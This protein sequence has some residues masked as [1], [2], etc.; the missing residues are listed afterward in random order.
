VEGAVPIFGLGKK[1][2]A[3][4][5]DGRP[6]RVLAGGDR[7]A[8]GLI[9]AAQAQDWSKIHGTLTRLQGR[10]LSAVTRSLCFH[11]ATRPW[12]L[13]VA[14]ANPDDFVSRLV[15]GGCMIDDAWQVR[16]NAR[17]QHVSRQQFT[18]FHEMLR[19]AEE[20]L[21]EAARID[22]EPSAPWYFL[23][24]TG[25][26]LGIGITIIERR[27]EAVTGRCPDHLDAHL[28]ML[29]SLCKKWY[30]S[31]ER[32]HEFAQAGINGPHWSTLALLVPRAH[33]ERFLDLGGGEPGRAYLADPKVLAEIQEA[34]DLTLGQPDYADPR[35]PS[36]RTGPG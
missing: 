24:E 5:T 18:T 21:Y 28:S 19:V 34:A 25:R 20:H 15:A 10:D 17:A 35:A 30:G 16:T 6:R 33:L 14:T 31:H 3:K 7:V 22:P 13:K 4:D 2:S 36:P 1:K 23:L 11:D 9:Q 27:F 29:Q 8:A 26:G 32:M 12:L